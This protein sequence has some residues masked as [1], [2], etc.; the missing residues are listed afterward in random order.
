MSELNHSPESEK[1]QEALAKAAAHSLDQSVDAM[2]DLSSYRIKQ[3]RQKV[4]ADSTTKPI[5]FEFNKH[6]AVAACLVVA[7][8]LPS[9]WLLHSSSQLES[10]EN[11]FI[12]PELSLD[13]QD[14]DDMDMLIAM[15]ESDA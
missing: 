10:E 15:G 2:D 14:F 11:A 9:V 1:F 12:S 4:L 8:G 3:I 13:A 5:R 6:W 7:V